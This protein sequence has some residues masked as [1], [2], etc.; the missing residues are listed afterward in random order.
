VCGVEIAVYPLEYSISIDGSEV[1]TIYIQEIKSQFNNPGRRCV[2][3]KFDLLQ[4]SEEVSLPELNSLSF[5]MTDP[6]NFRENADSRFE[7]FEGTSEIR[8]DIV[9]YLNSEKLRRMQKN[10][11]ETVRLF[12]GATAT[13]DNHY[14]LP[15]LV[16]FVKTVDFKPRFINE[17]PYS[18]ISI[19]MNPY[20]QASKTYS[21]LLPEAEDEEGGEIL[22]ELK[23]GN[24]EE[25]I[26][27][28]ENEGKYYVTID[29]S[30]ITPKFEGINNFRIKLSNPYESPR[31]YPM[32]IKV[33]YN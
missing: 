27:L 20:N 22:Y 5:D 26:K 2:I 33:L 6:K 12:V 9:V 19:N 17:F 31:D 14:Y 15:V 1:K 10:E 13:G 24:D 11:K 25:W 30:L 4:A 18:I 7:T 23:K 29:S 3:E 32:T 16:N 8:E 28:V 21:F